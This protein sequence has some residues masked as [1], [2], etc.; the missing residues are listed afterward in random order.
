MNVRIDISTPDDYDGLPELVIILTRRFQTH[1]AMQS[2]A[3]RLVRD[4][5]V[6]SL[7][8]GL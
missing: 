4:T 7:Q 1:D 6:L 3:P 8:N 5:A 2:I